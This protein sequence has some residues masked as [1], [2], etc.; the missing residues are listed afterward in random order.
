MPAKKYHF[1]IQIT[2]A[3]N[4]YFIFHYWPW[5]WSINTLQW[6]CHLL[7]HVD[8]TQIDRKP[9]FNDQLYQLEMKEFKDNNGQWNG[10]INNN[11]NDGF[12]LSVWRL[13]K[14]TSRHMNLPDQHM[15]L[16]IQRLLRS[17]TFDHNDVAVSYHLSHL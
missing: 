13:L 4:Q 11:E 3:N 15:L 14:V 7:Y 1:T 2:G 6:Y 8:R 16:F 9:P 5:C 12:C 10:M 17:P